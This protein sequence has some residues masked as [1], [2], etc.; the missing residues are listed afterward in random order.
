MK[1]QYQKGKRL[2]EIIKPLDVSLFVHQ[3][4]APLISAQANRQ[5]NSGFY[6]PQN[7]R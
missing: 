2:D 5:I 4:I 1:A 3:N 6:Y 7:K